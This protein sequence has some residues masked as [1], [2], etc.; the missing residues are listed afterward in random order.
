MQPAHWAQL[1]NAQRGPTDSITF[2][3]YDSSPDWGLGIV[4]TLLINML[5]TNVAISADNMV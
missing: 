5:L 1:N 2:M 3:G 4:Y